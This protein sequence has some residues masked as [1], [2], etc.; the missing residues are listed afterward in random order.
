MAEDNVGGI[1]VSFTADAAQLQAEIARLETQL[2][3]FNASYGK[4]TVQL[5][6]AT[7][8]RRSLLDT[9][10]EISNAFTAR[11][12]AGQIMAKVAVEA[13]AA[14]VLQTFRSQLARDIGSVTVNVKGRWAG[15]ET[16][17]PTSITVTQRGGGGG[18]AA[19]ATPLAGQ[20][21][22]QARAASPTATPTRGGRTPSSNT[23]KAAAQVSTVSA[24]QLFSKSNGWNDQTLLEEYLQGGGNAEYRRKLKDELVRRGFN[25]DETA[26][27][28]AAR[29]F[30]RTGGA[31]GF[32]NPVQLGA[33][34]S[35]SVS[36]RISP[37]AAAARYAQWFDLA[38][39]EELKEG[40]EWYDR[41]I[42]NLMK[43]TRGTGWNMEQ[44]RGITAAFSR[45]NSW[46]QNVTAVSKFAD[47]WRGGARALP[48]FQRQGTTPG[49]GLPSSIEDAIRI[50]SGDTAALAA[51]R[52][53]DPFSRA[54]G[55]D[56]DAKAIDRWMA[57][58]QGFVKPGE[59][60][61]QLQE[62]LDILAKQKGIQPRQAQ[63]VP[64]VVARN[65]LKNIKGTGTAADPAFAHPREGVDLPAGI[66][67]PIVGGARG[68]GWDPYANWQRQQ[69]REA[70]RR[71]LAAKN[72]YGMPGPRP[73]TNP[74]DQIGSPER[75]AIIDEYFASRRT[76]GARGFSD[77]DPYGRQAARQP[78]T[79]FMQGRAMGTVPGLGGSFDYQRQMEDE[80]RQSLLLRRMQER[81]SAGGGFTVDPRTGQFLDPR[82]GRVGP[83]L[84]ATGQSV[85]GTN[86][87]QLMQQL[88]ANPA[89]ARE[90]AT[91]GLIGGWR[92]PETGQIDLDVS[93]EFRTRRAMLAHLATRPD[94]MA[95]YALGAGQDVPNPAYRTA[96]GLTLA[97]IEQRRAA[98]RS[99]YAKLVAEG[100]AGPGIRG[101][102]PKGLP[103]VNQ[104]RMAMAADLPW[105]DEGRLPGD[106]G[107]GI[108]ARAFGLMSE[109]E[110]RLDAPVMG[111]KRGGR[112][113]VLPGG[114]QRR[115]RISPAARAETIAFDANLQE[116]QRA[117][118]QFQERQI[119]TAR[120]SSIRSVP[121]FLAGILSGGLGGVAAQE[122][123]KQATVAVNAHRAALK[124][125]TDAQTE[126]NEI[127]KR[128]DIEK[129]GTEA[130]KALTGSLEEA[131]IKVKDLTAAEKDLRIQADEMTRSANK[132]AG[133]GLRNLAAGFASNLAAGLAFGVG[134]TALQGIITG[135]GQ[136]LAPTVA[137]MNNFSEVAGETSK[138]LAETVRQAHGLADVGLA[139]TFAAAGVKGPLAAQIGPDLLQV[140]QIQAGLS[141]F[142][143]QS[144]L[145]DTAFNFRNGN[146]IPG[147]TASTGGGLFGIGAEKG[148]IETLKEQIQ[149]IVPERVGG[150]A[151]PRGGRTIT[152]PGA[153][154]QVIDRN[155]KTLENVNQKLSL[156]GITLEAATKAGASASE[157]QRQYDSI[158]Q[159]GGPQVQGFVDAL[160]QHG[161]FVLTDQQG[162][163]LSG[164][165]LKEAVIDGLK[166]MPKATA[167]SIIDGMRPQ[168]EAQRALF[169]LQSDFQRD[170]LNPAQF[171]LQ[172]AA[173]PL[174]RQGGF[175][176]RPRNALTGQ[177]IP[178]P[179][180]FRGEFGQDG[181]AVGAQ[182]TAA[183]ESL[184]PL[185]D[186]TDSR[187]MELRT[188]GQRAL[189]AL[190]PA[191][192]IVEFRALNRE[193]TNVGEAIAGLQIGVQQEQV[194]F[195]VAQYNNQLRIAHRSQTDLLQLTGQLGATQGDNLGLLQR[196]MI[197]YERQTQELSLQSNELTL[198]SNTLSIILAQR[199]INFQRSL[200]GFVTPGETPQEI[201]ARAR[202]AELEANFAQKQLDIQKEQLKL[203]REQQGIAGKALPLQFQ[204]QDVGFQRQL[205]DINAEIALLNQGIRLTVNT[206]AAERAIAHLT[207][208]ENELVKRAGTYVD[209]GAKA[210][211]AFMEGVAQVKA[212]TVDGMDTVIRQTANAWNIFIRQGVYAVGALTG[213]PGIPPPSNNPSDQDPDA[214]FGGRQRAEGW[215]GMVSGA[216]RITVGEAGPETVAIIR[217]PRSWTPAAPSSGGWSGGGGNITVMVTGNQIGGSEQDQERFAAIIARKV[218]EIQSRRGSLLGL[219]SV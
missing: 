23:A 124:Q 8:S 30:A 90:L 215:Y 1:S 57:V 84:A 141:A 119:R 207:A 101:I 42:G 122:Q 136:A 43:A 98:G 38:T 61:D 151:G 86:L 201:A 128:L 192:Q 97:Q 172:L 148:L 116:A 17:P 126:E 145:I 176:E 71:M 144:A 67:D 46:K 9:R 152:F 153:D 105:D 199:Q 56:M 95:G 92:N 96:S 195:Q 111:G 93:R 106:E 4:Q 52:K 5:Q 25:P 11:G 66:L 68:F 146:G 29:G 13:P 39:P 3:R 34:P 20:R 75:Q 205:T 53:E 150:G 33:A 208:L 185:L 171:A 134:F 73:S 181:G 112:G 110:A 15:W 103:I 131:R 78:Q 149:T 69:G 166:D 127:A 99:S 26:G 182:F 19:A 22:A 133:T 219:R 28:P 147:I 200:A 113:K 35:K 206:A 40:M 132:A 117:Q 51:H 80:A 184:G 137:R 59:A 60:F 82:R 125:L 165:R 47:R 58:M 32:T 10:R 138:N 154:T 44:V 41:E 193:I 70:N 36:A 217:N 54:L 209:E 27:R 214:T 213:G 218:E 87:E 179:A 63:A 109:E 55:G 6:V 21:P 140:A 104:P 88:R 76:G 72:P 130:H 16:P 89:N 31:R 160:E 174:T 198:Q 175:G 177:R 2:K 197:M 173:Q 183:F 159:L 81:M 12:A 120:A 91:G 62:A 161:G 180:L 204:I 48:Q 49:V 18:G 50:A 211:G 94:Q 118:E 216:T 210:A 169:R 14:R 168:I 194:N 123:S 187:L 186:E 45:N 107:Y 108:H 188:E 163:V 135:V 7:P 85:S 155:A 139:Q 157:Q 64:W 164:D 142:R 24:Q 143:D 202:E 203:A 121:T 178:I 191:D 115:A 100:R 74:L 162:Q 37:Q 190:V 79:G 167:K 129:P 212:A 170:Q 65:R 114:L 189:E 77:F 156:F 102:L 196:Q 83:F 158:L